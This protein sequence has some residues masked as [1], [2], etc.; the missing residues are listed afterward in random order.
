MTTLFVL[1]AHHRK[2]LRTHY[3]W[4][5]DRVAL[6]EIASRPEFDVYDVIPLVP[7]GVQVKHGREVF[8][9]AVVS[10]GQVG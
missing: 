3:Y 9:E 5:A 7:A 6:E 4:G 8:A 2:T 1:S 10:S